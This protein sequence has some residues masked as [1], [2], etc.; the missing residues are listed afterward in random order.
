LLA[1]DQSEGGFGIVLVCRTYLYGG[2]QLTLVLLGYVDLVARPALALALVTDAHLRVHHAQDA[3]LGYTPTQPGSEIL[4][5]GAILL[6]RFQ[7]ASLFLLF[8]RATFPLWTFRRRRSLFD[9]VGYDLLKQRGGFIRCGAHA[10]VV[11]R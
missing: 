8:G 10:A 5:G 9:I 2:D 7:P 1:F 6:L 11:L 4:G 3:I